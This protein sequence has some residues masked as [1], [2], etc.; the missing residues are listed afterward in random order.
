MTMTTRRPMSTRRRLIALAIVGVSV[1]VVLV[2]VRTAVAEVYYVPTASVA[3]E[4]PQGAR[5]L[6]SKLT[7]T[8]APGQII[9]Y[10]NTRGR[11]WL[12]RVAAVDESSGRIELSRHP[13]TDDS[14]RLDDV[15]G[16]VVL[17]TR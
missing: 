12:G 8:Y 2:S 17:T 11:I 6:V 9:A 3:P 16:R 5:V 15:I 1:L 13:P 14:V 7:R 10:R 4:V